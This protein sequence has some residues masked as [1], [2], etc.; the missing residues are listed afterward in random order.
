MIKTLTSI[1]FISSLLYITNL[2]VY[3]CWSQPCEMYITAPL[4][5]LLLLVYGWGLTKL[6]KAVNKLIKKQEK[7]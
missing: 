6:N 4:G 2:Y 1:L 7:L 3:Y 5:I